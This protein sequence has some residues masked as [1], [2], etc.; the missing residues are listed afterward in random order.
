MVSGELLTMTDGP[1]ADDGS[2]APVFILRVTHGVDAGQSLLLD[3]SKRSS[4]LIGQ[5]P[6]CDLR[7]RDLRV[8]R[9]HLEIAPAAALLRAT[10]L[11]SSNGTAVGGLRIVQALL[12]GGELIVIG[13]TQLRI[14]RAP[15]AAPVLPS[16]RRG[17]GRVVGASFEMQRV[18]EVAEK[19][20]GS[21]LPLIIEGETGTGKELLAE[22]IHEAGATAAG[23]FVVVE[24]AASSAE[25]LASAFARAAGGTLVLSEIGDLEAEAQASLVRLVDEPRAQRVR[26]IASARRDTD[27]DVQDGRL[28]EDLMYRL[29]GARIEMPPLRRRHGDVALLAQHFW[30]IYAPNLEPPAPLLVKLARASWPG[31]VRELQSAIARAVALGP[32]A[33]EE[34]GSKLTAH[35]TPSALRENVIAK[36][37]ELDLPLA[38]ARQLVVRELERRYV[39]RALSQHDGNVTRAAAASG[40]TRRYFHLLMAELRPKP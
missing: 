34:Y 23:P 25:D 18:F 24:C 31:N 30:S 28:R 5:G 2:P 14:A 33:A 40:L 20:A 8:S 37:L 12:A 35:A 32:D 29:A 9:R 3:W 17:F 6:L 4:Y 21:D 13:D 16:S 39:E 11:G 19:L 22:A 15:I 38:A 1:L 26:V 7:L 27:R 36:T 10:D